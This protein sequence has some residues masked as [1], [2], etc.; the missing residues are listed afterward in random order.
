MKKNFTTGICY[1]ED[2]KPPILIYK[3][4]VNIN[5]LKKFVE[6]Y[7]NSRSKR[8]AQEQIERILREALLQ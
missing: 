1:S 5:N 8:I 6:R 7:G 3:I 4:V 2:S